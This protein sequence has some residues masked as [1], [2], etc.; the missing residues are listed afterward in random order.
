MIWRAI[1]GNQKLSLQFINIEMNATDY[2][3]V[4]ERE[5]PEMIGKTNGD[6][7]LLQDNSSVHKARIV[8]YWIEQHNVRLIDFPRLSPDLNVIENIWATKEMYINTFKFFFKTIII[9]FIQ[10]SNRSM[11]PTIQTI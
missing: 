5:L 7:Y 3:G 8:M 10:N 4:L 11:T 2:I 6:F 9:F 1:V